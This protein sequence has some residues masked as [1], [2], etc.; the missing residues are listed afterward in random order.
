MTSHQYNYMNANQQTASATT[1][2]SYFSQPP[3]MN[4]NSSQS[5]TPDIDKQLNS[6]T[7]SKALTKPPSL[8]SI[9][10]PV[11]GI[12]RVY[13][14]GSLNGLPP[15]PS[16]MQQQSMPAM[17]IAALSGSN[18]IAQSKKAAEPATSLLPPSMASLNLNHSSASTP[19]SSLTPNAST[20]N[21]LNASTNSSGNSSLLDLNNSNGRTATPPVVN[22]AAASSQINFSNSMPSS[23]SH[24]FQQQQPSKHQMPPIRPNLFPQPVSTPSLVSSNTPTMHMPPNL[25]SSQPAL[26]TPFIRSLDTNASQQMF[27]ANNDT[28]NKFSPTPTPL[29]TPFPSSNALFNQQQQQTT[30]L[31]GLNIHLTFTSFSDIISRIKCNQMNVFPSFI[32][33][34][35]F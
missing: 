26:G 32:S 11:G 20:N 22:A 12:P 17:P 2:S 21:L 33:K 7:L 14:P 18:L 10:N 23:S 35:F 31:L 19:P 3:N 28:L 5:S 1:A 9:L 30:N 15:M 25:Q 29:S 27:S 16:L 24:L 13:N 34:I 6:A 4:V 8:S